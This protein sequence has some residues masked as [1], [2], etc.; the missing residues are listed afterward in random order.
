MISRRWFGL[1]LE[2]EFELERSWICMG[3]IPAANTHN[4]TISPSDDT[5]NYSAELRRYMQ[6]R[7]ASF[8]REQGA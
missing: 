7:S 2:L 6:N 5:I 8:S 1:E 4:P 3:W